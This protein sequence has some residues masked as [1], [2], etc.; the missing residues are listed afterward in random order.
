LT[1]IFKLGHSRIPIFRA[2][3]DIIDDMNER[4][5]CIGLLYVKDLILVDPDDNIPITKVLET[6]DHH[7]LPIDVWKTDDLNEVMQKF[8]ESCQHLAFVKDGNPDF[9]EDVEY[10]GIVTLEDVIEEILKKELVDEYD[11]YVDHKDKKS[12]THR[13]NEIDWENSLLKREE[14]GGPVDPKKEEKEENQDTKEGR[15]HGTDETDAGDGTLE[16]ASND[17]DATTVY[18]ETAWWNVKGENV[19]GVAARD[20]VDQFASA[21][22][23]DPDQIE[24]VQLWPPKQD[25]KF[26]LQSEIGNYRFQIVARDQNQCDPGEFLC[27]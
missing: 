7:R 13:L 8:T 24:N 1:E 3:D 25:F 2:S 20:D 19:Y 4:P 22:L 17:D 18:V 6:F 14:D 16:M 5:F 15:Y 12:T 9:P 23:C 11:N 26:H 21:I 10:V 27:H